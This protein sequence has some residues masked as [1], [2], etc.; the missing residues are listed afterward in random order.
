MACLYCNEKD[1]L[2]LNFSTRVINDKVKTIEVCFS[3]YWREKFVA[4]GE[5]GIQRKHTIGKTLF[6]QRE[7]SVLQ[8][9]VKLRR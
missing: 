2:K 6:E 4:E 5:N 7:P 1:P 9:R 8:S 3:C